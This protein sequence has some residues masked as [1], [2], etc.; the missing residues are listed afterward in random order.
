[1]AKFKDT[2]KSNGTKHI[3][4]LMNVQE[5]RIIL[6]YV[7]YEM[8]VFF[9]LNMCSKPTFCSKVAQKRKLARGC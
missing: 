1:M 6:I 3:K 5:I 7:F 9:M 2:L 4:R 8:A